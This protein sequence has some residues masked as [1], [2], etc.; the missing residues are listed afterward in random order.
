M[1]CNVAMMFS[2]FSVIPH[3]PRQTICSDA[4]TSPIPLTSWPPGQPAS[5]SQYM[6]PLSS[7]KGSRRTISR[8]TSKHAGVITTPSPTNPKPTLLQTTKQSTPATAQAMVHT[9][10]KPKVQAPLISQSCAQCFAQRFAQWCGQWCSQPARGG[11]G[12]GQQWASL[13]GQAS[14]MHV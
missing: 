7:W 2:F 3:I 9:V 12:A 1:Q 8:G 10:L 11:K 13:M 14:G 4:P 5:I 6:A